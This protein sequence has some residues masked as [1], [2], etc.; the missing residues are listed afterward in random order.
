MKT[1]TLLTTIIIASLS[2]GACSTTPDPVEI[3]SAEWIT[4]R[5]DRAMND[6]ERDTSKIFK[7]FRKAADS[8]QN[9]GNIGPLQMFSIMNALSSLADKFENG[10][11]VRDMRILAQT[12]DDPQLIKNAMTD[13]MRSKGLP[14]SFINFI[15]GIDEYQKLLDTSIRPDSNI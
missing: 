9:G 5:L 15:N 3:C 8:L 11:A 13:F 1:K 4:P 10:R 7:K 6:F 12:C 2:L 14:D